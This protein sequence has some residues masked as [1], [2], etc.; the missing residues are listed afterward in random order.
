M[1]ALAFEVLRAELTRRCLEAGYGSVYVSRTD[2]IG[3]DHNGKRYFDKP[4]PRIGGW[5]AIWKITEEVIGPI[6]CG[7]GHQCYFDSYNVSLQIS[8]LLKHA[9]PESAFD[10]IRAKS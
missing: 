6:S 2:C 4:G 3:L 1:S 5:P 10:M 9:P 8:E 7:N